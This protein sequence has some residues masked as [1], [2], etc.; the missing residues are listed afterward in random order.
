MYA[1]TLVRYAAD[2]NGVFQRGELG[3]GRQGLVFAVLEADD[4]QPW[5]VWGREDRPGNPGDRPHV[6]RVMVQRVSIP[7]LESMDAEGRREQYEEVVQHAS[8]DPGAFFMEGGRELKAFLEL[9]PFES[10]GEVVET[11]WYHS[12]N[13]YFTAFLES[14]AAEN[15]AA[16]EAREAVMA[17]SAEGG[18][19]SEEARE[20]V[21][22]YTVADPIRESVSACDPASGMPANDHSALRERLARYAQLA[23][24]AAEEAAEKG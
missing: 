10:K 5:F 11:D 2:R 21:A 1:K 3:R 22:Q 13:G 14:Q 19:V 24:E 7:G 15:T 20:A 12:M 6:M 23:E 9:R 8:I 17:Y 18:E 16:E 4:E